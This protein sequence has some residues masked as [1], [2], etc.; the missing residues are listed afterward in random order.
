MESQ[1][2]LKV[3]RSES[4]DRNLSASEYSASESEADEGLSSKEPPL[5][6]DSTAANGEDSDMVQ[7]GDDVPDDT[8]ARLDG[9]HR[10]EE[11][12]A[13]IQS[14]TSGDSSFVLDDL[15]PEEAIAAGLA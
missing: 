6:D 10:S 7:S 2:T 1:E 4:S 15:S 13:T 14:A 8:T 9:P 12:L 3:P 11:H 5:N